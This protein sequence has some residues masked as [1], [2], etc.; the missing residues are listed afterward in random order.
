MPRPLIVLLIVA[1]VALLLGS[2]LV[3]PVAA[4]GTPTPRPVSD[5]D[6]NR[7][8]RN[9]YCPVCQ[10]V[11]LE[12]CETQ[13][14]VRWREQIRDLLSQGYTDEQVRQYFIERFGAK[15][16]GAP[17]DTVSQ[18]LTIALPFALIGL[19]GVVVV[20]N[21]V[22]WRRSRYAEPHSE[23]VQPENINGGQAPP[24]DYRARLEAEIRKR[25]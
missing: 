25:D 19:I 13:A 7:V 18:L 17:T 11:P 5:N 1:V 20:F 3:G 12:V 9:L 2:G 24:G 10:N 4:Q 23:N 15:T 21:L 14:C 6:V 8:A 22:R 16:V